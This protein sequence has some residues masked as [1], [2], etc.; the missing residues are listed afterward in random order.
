MDWKQ[1][2]REITKS[3]TLVPTFEQW[4]DATGYRDYARGIGAGSVNL[5]AHAMNALFDYYQSEIQK[6]RP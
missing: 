2:L 5:Q 3:E 1:Q 4:L 6:R